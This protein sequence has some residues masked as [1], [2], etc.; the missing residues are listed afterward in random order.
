ML[1]LFFL[2]AG[3]LL[4]PALAQEKGYEYVVTL[5]SGVTLRGQ[6][7]KKDINGFITLKNP[8]KGILTINPD[9]ISFMQR[10]EIPA[11]AEFALQNTTADGTFGF[12]LSSGLMIGMTDQTETGFQFQSVAFLRLNENFAL[13]AGFGIERANHATWLPAF[14]QLRLD[15]DALSEAPFFAINVGYAGLVQENSY[16]DRGGLLAAAELGVKFPLASENVFF[17]S[18]TYRYQQARLEQFLYSL[19][20]PVSVGSEIYPPTYTT[21]DQTINYHFVVVSIG[22]IF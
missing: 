11:N 16:H 12:Q 13:G 22:I 21:F 20:N 9:E 19:E 3:S 14:G 10:E 4:K 1:L 15:L 2:L 17:I 5:K 8:E 18:A 6:F 7:I